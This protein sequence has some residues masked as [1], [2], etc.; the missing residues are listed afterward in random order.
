MVPKARIDI[1]ASGKNLACIKN[2]H[3]HC[4]IVLKLISYDI[5]FSDL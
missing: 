4:Q 1:R 3:F 5:N 2:I